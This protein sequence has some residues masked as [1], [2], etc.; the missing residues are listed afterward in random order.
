LLIPFYVI[1]QFGYVVAF[2]TPLLR[3]VVVIGVLFGVRY[4]SGYYAFGTFYVVCVVVDVIQCNPIGCWCLRCYCCFRVT[5]CDLFV[6]CCVNIYCVSI[7]LLITP[8]S[9]DY[10]FVGVVVDCWTIWFVLLVVVV[11]V[12]FFFFL[13]YVVGDLLLL[14]TRLC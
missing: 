8:I 4:Y 14:L 13:R 10:R 7:L 3:F 5:F 9:V 1:I 2:A 12:F 6:A 11:V